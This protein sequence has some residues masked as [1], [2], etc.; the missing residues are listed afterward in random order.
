MRQKEPPAFK[1]Q[2]VDIGNSRLGV[3]RKAAHALADRGHDRG[4][5]PGPSEPST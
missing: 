2:D 3:R 4:H 5:D 1:W